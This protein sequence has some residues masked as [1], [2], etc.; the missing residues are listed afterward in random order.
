MPVKIKKPTKTVEKRRKDGSLRK[1]VIK[2]STPT[3]KTRDVQKQNK[4]GDKVT[5]KTKTT[6]P[7]ASK[8]KRTITTKAKLSNF[9][10]TD[11]YKV[12]KAKVKRKLGGKTYGKSKAKGPAGASALLKSSGR[13]TGGGL[14]GYARPKTGRRTT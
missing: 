10:G 12:V 9:K 8:H 5:V 3:R 4:A 1:R 11:D 7:T 6:S 13:R 14:R 2:T